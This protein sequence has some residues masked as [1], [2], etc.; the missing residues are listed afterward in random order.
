[1]FYEVE[2]F[3]IDCARREIDK[4]SLRVIRVFRGGHSDNL[5]SQSP[6]VAW[7]L[8]RGYDASRYL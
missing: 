1:M 7:L 4:L 6:N 2:R 5:E 3:M 8:P